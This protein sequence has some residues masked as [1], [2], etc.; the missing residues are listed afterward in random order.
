MPLVEPEKTTHVSDA[1]RQFGRLKVAVLIGAAVL[2]SGLA[3]LY[4]REDPKR[5]E[6]TVSQ[7]VVTP[8]AN[9][10]AEQPVQ[11]TAQ[12][13]PQSLL[14]AKQV[15]AGLRQFQGATESI[16]NY[17]DYDESLTQ[18]KADLNKML[19]SFVDHKPGDEFFRREVDAAMRDYT[20]AG[21]WWKTVERNGGVLSDADRT[22]RLVASW[23]SAKTHLDNAEQMLGR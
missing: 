8:R 5:T 14:A 18:L 2:I 12:E 6:G 23:A 10:E 22:E 4:L 19:P 20:A 7:A 17:D 15:L 16:K 1:P 9:P 11:D 21:S 3:F 13:Y